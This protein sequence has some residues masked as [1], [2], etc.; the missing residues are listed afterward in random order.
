M[1][2]RRFPNAVFQAAPAAGPTAGFLKLVVHTPNGSGIA[3]NQPILVAY[4]AR[5]DFDKRFLADE[6]EPRNKK[7]KAT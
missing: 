6:N 3:A 7:F 5:Y 2:K 1:G 4:G